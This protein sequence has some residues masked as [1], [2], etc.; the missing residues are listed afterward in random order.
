MSND[1]KSKIRL[2]M[3]SGAP[4]FYNS[5][6]RKFKGAM[7]GTS[8]KYRKY[9][10]FDYVYSEEFQQYTQDYIDFLKKE[11]SNFFVYANLDVI[12][13]A[14]LTWQQQLLLE[15]NGLSPAPVFH[16]SSPEKYLK[17]YVD[18]YEYIA[19]GGIAGSPKK[20]LVPTLDYLFK[21]YI[22]D[23]KGKPRVKVHGLATTSL[24]LMQRYPWYSVDS[25][26]CMKYAIYGKIIIPNISFT[27]FHTLKISDR[28]PNILQ[29]ISPEVLKRILSLGEMYNCTLEELMSDFKMRA[30]WNYLV[31]LDVLYSTRDK[32]ARGHIMDFYF[33]G[34]LTKEFEIKFWNRVAASDTFKYFNLTRLFSFMYKDVYL[35]FKENEKSI[36]R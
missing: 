20:E 4:T 13:N 35:N 9:D 16:I 34:F 36:I 2:F 3:D 10:N 23:D 24:P 7:M 31:F 19:I 27:N 12:N 28:N 18:N 33:A 26:S 21:K 8:L 15:Q 32:F 6:S 30:L 22:I 1:I 11:S 25:A 17:R 14:E 29:T 5:F